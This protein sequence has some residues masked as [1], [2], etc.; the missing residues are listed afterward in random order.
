MAATPD[1]IAFVRAR[2]KLPGLTAERELRIVRELAAQLDDFY[3]DALARGLSEIDADAYTRD[4]VRDWDRMAQDVWLA[5]RRHAK[6]RFDR[7]EQQ[8][9]EQAEMV[10]RSACQSIEVVVKQGC[11]VTQ[12]PDLKL[13]LF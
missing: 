12:R 5:D 8:I 10:L 13:K 3:R 6:P 2:L 1:W 7:S 9:I 11:A 4:Q